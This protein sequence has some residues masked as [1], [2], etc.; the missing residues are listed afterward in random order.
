[1]NLGTYQAIF[2][3]SCS[4]NNLKLN[5]FEVIKYK[6]VDYHSQAPKIKLTNLQTEI[7]NRDVCKMEVFSVFSPNISEKLCCQSFPNENVQNK[8]V[9]RVD[10][11]FFQQPA[12][13]NM[14]FC[15]EIELK[16][17]NNSNKVKK[18]IQKYLIYPQKTRFLTLKNN[19]ALK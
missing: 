2:L 19:L 9:L 17:K 4:L 18:N 15:Y 10:N 16:Y 13:C 14:F 1:M 12:L 3:L 5:K 7:N 6:L 11:H 8:R